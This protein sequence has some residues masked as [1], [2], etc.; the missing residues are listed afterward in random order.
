ML[1][2]LVA[3]MNIAQS[4]VQFL[5]DSGVDFIS[6]DEQGWHNL[7]DT[8]ILNRAHAMNRFVLT[9]DSDFGTL[10]IRDGVPITGIIYLRSGDRPSAQVIADLQALL[11]T[12]VDWTPPLIAV[13]QSGRLRLHRPRT[14][15]V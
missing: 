11:N 10:A 15:T 14:I 8:E 2:A 13:Y 7:T 1:P 12:D 9:H 3:D 5:R 4:V 6:A